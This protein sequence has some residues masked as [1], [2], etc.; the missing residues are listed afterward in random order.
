MDRLLQDLRYALRRLTRTPGFT[1]TAVLTLALAVG[2]TTA[3]LSIFDSVVLKPLPYRNPQTLA[4]VTSTIGEEPD[5]LSPPDFVDYRAQNHSF[6]SLAVYDPG[7]TSTLWRTN[8]PSIRLNAALVGADF[9][10][11]L[12]VPSAIGRTFAS[13]EDQPS[14]PK[15]A[16]VSY[17]AWQSLL[18]GDSAV[19]GR[20]IILDGVSYTLIGI[21]PKGFGFPGTPDVWVP[22]VFTPADLAPSSRSG[23]SLQA[24]GRLAPGVTGDAASRDIATIASRLANQYPRTNVRTG[25]LV[26][27]LQDRVVGPSG[28]ALGVMLVGVAL[29]FLIACANVANLMLVRAAGR[30]SEVAVRSALGAGRAR[31]L[32]EALT[33][34]VLVSI[35]GTALGVLLATRLVDLVVAYGPRGLPRLSEITLNGSVLGVTVVLALATGVILG[36]LPAW[37]AWRS[38][39]SQMIRRGPRTATPGA[40]RTRGVLVAGEMALAVMLLV[41]SGLLLKSYRRLTQVDPGFHPDH[42]LTFNVDLPSTTYPYDK[43]TLGYVN[44]V[45]PELHA[46]PGVTDVTAAAGRPIQP[47]APFSAVAGMKF[48]SGRPADEPGKQPG[49]RVYAV[50]PSF[51]STFRIPIVRGRAFSEAENMP[52]TQA[53]VV[54]EEFVRKFSHDQDPIGRR[55]LVGLSHTASAA[56]SDTVRGGGDIVGVAADV[57][58]GSLADAATPTVYIPYGANPFGVSI[59]VRSAQDPMLLERQIRARVEAVDPQAAIYDV[60]TMDAEIAAS[61]SQPRFY[62]LL[63]S[64]FS[65]LAL[66]LAGLGVFGVVSYA[67]GQR[68]RE[69]GIR[70]ALGAAPRDL[71]RLVM[72][73]GVGL[74]GAGLVVGI[75]L[76]AILTRQLASLLFT[77]TPLDPATFAIAGSVLLVAAGAASFI[78]ARRAAKVDPVVAMRVE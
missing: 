7:N 64:G 9:F 46:L 55:L 25:G 10:S 4:Y 56:P 49:L 51:F 47:D 29:V 34:S 14:S 43:E 67:V 37:H 78:P 58:V 5:Y 26:Q 63:L 70:V 42:L 54:N 16:V 76:A 24:I 12:G 36:L 44:R 77:V 41:A 21:A 23:H 61:V 1:A 33:E 11:I 38:D 57:K 68:T 53:V 8:Q 50:S 65:A 18:G 30:E 71:L 13:G 60:T 75:G 32:R 39:V 2:A 20:P 22:R 74:A 45:V 31:I 52:K 27:L 15:T 40:R 35:T 69:L 28:Q 6:T 59:T 62:A 48:L 73:D 17:H 19:V 72:G 66:L 3:M